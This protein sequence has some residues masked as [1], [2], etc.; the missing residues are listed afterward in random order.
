M[1]FELGTIVLLTV[2]NGCFSGAEIAL[3]ALRKTRLQ[4][5][6]ENGSSQAGAALRLRKDP[7]RLLATVQVGITV[8][9]ASTAVFGGAHFEGPL[10]RLLSSIGLEP[11]APQLSFVVVVGLVS[12]LS[13]VIGELVPKSLALHAPERFAL[14]MAR[15]LEWLAI[16]AKPL[17]WILTASSNL[18]LGLFR[19]KTTFS[20]S[21]LSPEEVQQ[22]VEE[23]GAVGALNVS[24][25]DIASRAID[26]GQLRANALMVP[27][28]RVTSL[29]V[30]ATSYEVLRVLREH[31]HARYPVIDGP[32]NVLGYVVARDVLRVLAEGRELSLR[33]LLR[34]VAYFP[35]KVLAVDVVRQLQQRKQQLALLV[36]ETGGLDGLFTIEDVAEEL[37]G[38]IL[39]EDE[40]IRSLAWLDT[41]GGVIALGEAPIHEIERL[42]DEDFGVERSDVTT[43]AGVLMAQTGRVPVAGEHVRVG[44]HITAEVLEATD[45]V[46]VRARLAV[47]KDGIPSVRPPAPEEDG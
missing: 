29:P 20:E 38:D 14:P 43:V 11:F 10:V 24:A 40:V 18:V 6:T 46:I 44:R 32:E 12:Y 42:L 36:D 34:P 16:G 7:E 4:E 9:G 22:L 26:L 2:L 17:V 21:R 19:D 39:E 47:T 28:I 25:A 5:L 3:L 1:W 13:L 15:P 35:S 33:D 30:G 37:L 8:I 23:S 41:S 31:P 27:R 45:R